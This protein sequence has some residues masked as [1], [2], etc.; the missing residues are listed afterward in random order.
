MICPEGKENT[1]HF[2]NNKRQRAFRFL[3]E[4]LERALEKLAT[5]TSPCATAHARVVLK[6]P[7]RKKAEATQTKNV[8]SA[9]LKETRK[10][11]HTS[12]K[13][14]LKVECY[15]C[16][17]DSQFRCSVVAAC[18]KLL[19]HILVQ[20]PGRADKQLWAQ[21]TVCLNFHMNDTNNHFCAN[22]NNNG[23][24]HTKYLFY[25]DVKK[26]VLNIDAHL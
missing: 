25:I 12:T 14:T 8:L 19:S 4:Q 17:V 5:K 23:A 1:I 9:M 13:S 6:H 7:Q 16:R 15:E 18:H 21:M 20:L 26:K 2:I 11:L 24:K 3:L 10:K 22:S